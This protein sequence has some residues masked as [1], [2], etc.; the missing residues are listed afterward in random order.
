MTGLWLLFRIW[1]ANR[2][3]DVSK[4]AFDLS[5]ATIK[6]S[7]ALAPDEVECRLRRR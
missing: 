1:L 2:L 4:A 5:E 6:W 7:R 3:L